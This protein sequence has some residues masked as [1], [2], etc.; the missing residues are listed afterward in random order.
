M[1]VDP[2]GGEAAPADTKASGSTARRL[3]DVELGELLSNGNWVRHL[4][5]RLLFD[6][7]MVDDVVQEV[8]ITALHRPPRDLRTF[9]VWLRRVVHSLALRANRAAGRQRR[10]EARTAAPPPAPTP[11]AVRERLETQAAIGAEVIALEEPYRAIIYLR[12]Y[13]ELKLVEIARCLGLSDSTV[14]TRFARA[15]ELLR[16]RLGRRLGRDRWH[17]ALWQVVFPAGDGGSPEIAGVTGRARSV[18]SWSAVV[19]VAAATAGFVWTAPSSSVVDSAMRRDRAAVV[20]APASSAATTVESTARGRARAA[21]RASAGRAERGERSE[22]TTPEPPEAPEPL[23]TT[24]PAGL[25]GDDLLVVECASTGEPIAGA[26]VG[27]FR[28]TEAAATRTG[29]TDSRGELAVPRDIL[30]REALVVVAPG[31]VEYREPV[32]KRELVNRRHRVALEPSFDLIVRVLDA[33]G[34]ALAGVEVEVRP[35]AVVGPRRDAVVLTTGSDGEVAFAYEHRETEIR[36]DLSGQT[37][38]A[39]WAK[40]PATEVR[41]APAHA[42]WGRLLDPG[43]APV[44]DAPVHVTSEVRRAIPTEVVTD[45]GGRFPLGRIAGDERVEVRVHSEA[46]PA[47]REV[48]LPPLEGDWSIRLPEAMHVTGTV[49]GP[50]GGTVSEG[51]VFLVRPESPDPP[52]ASGAV[53]R[54]NTPRPPASCTKSRRLMPRVRTPIRD[55]G[56]FELGP[57]ARSDG[58]GAYLFVFHPRFQDHLEVWDPSEPW[59]PRDIRLAAGVELEGRAVTPAGAPCAGL[60]LHLGEIYSDGTENVVGRARAGGDGRFRFTGVPSVVREELSGSADD[61]V[62]RERLVLEAFAPDRLLSLDGVSIETS[63]IPGGFS[64]DPAR[65]QVLELVAAA[66]AASRAFPL[67]LVD[68]RANPEVRWIPAVLLGERAEIRSGLAATIAGETLVYGDSPIAA[69]TMPA[70]LLLL[71]PDGEWIAVDL[72]RTRE[73]AAAGE[74]VVIAERSP[75]PVRLELRDAAGK[76]RTGVALFA[77]APFVAAGEPRALVRLGATGDDGTLDIDFLRVP[78]IRLFA[79]SAALPVETRVLPYRGDGSSPAPEWREIAV[80]DLTPGGRVV[81]S[82][83]EDLARPD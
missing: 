11:A 74:T 47:Y 42:R 40:P 46:W 44:A 1:R 57:I 7:S 39:V 79:T 66:Q 13:E 31:R 63:E 3:S 50:D 55:D 49:T 5:R 16:E 17:L 61:P 27:F 82:L 32:L 43:G 34:L 9:P 15:L 70:W 73:P 19:I 69:D 48:G 10:H 71:P 8:W 56:S 6:E 22:P 60:Q 65:R 45:A 78:C 18:A 2:T 77:G 25:A 68:E 58:D 62:I 67:R 81:V 52:T 38:I 4:A 14:R 26:H 28:R 12:F 54:V 37:E 29:T 80:V 30:E 51:F 33:Q 75:H 21:E 59:R 72:G 83:P 76:P 41:L 24:D 35:R 20:V 64:I 23:A 53:A 36:I